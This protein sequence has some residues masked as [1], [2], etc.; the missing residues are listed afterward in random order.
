MYHP[1]RFILASA[2]PRR[3]E[4]LARGGYAF[5]VVPPH[6]DE[7]RHPDEAPS[8]Y[9]R[10]LALEKTASVALGHPGRVV[11]GADTTVVIEGRVLGKPSD[12]E[13]AAGML[14]ALS[15]RAH[16]VLTGVA[17][18][19]AE[20]SVSEVENTTVT[21]APLDEATIA[22]YVGTGEP[23][24]KAG[25]YGVQGIAS[26]FVTRVDG[27]YSN[28]V[29]LPLSVVDRLFARVSKDRLGAALTGSRVGDILSEDTRGGFRKSC[30]TKR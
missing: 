14:R 4:L 1:P 11:L 27:S 20:R 25:G 19:L 22:W 5:D 3:Q 21:L 30:R 28:V 2:S 8:D 9:V 17:V 26:R 10:R 16:E 13:D 7:Q 18:R 24:D 29:G 12:H 6:V 15:G 23:L